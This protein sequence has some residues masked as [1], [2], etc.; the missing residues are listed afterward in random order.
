MIVQLNTLKDFSFLFMKLKKDELYEKHNKTEILNN[1]FV[2]K[3]VEKI[4]LMY[5]EFQN[6][7]Q[8]ALNEV[9]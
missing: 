2:N 1:I 9:V 6:N 4:K 5:I 3:I 8:D 7:N